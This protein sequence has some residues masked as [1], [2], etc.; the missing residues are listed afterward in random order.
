MIH[1]SS[2]ISENAV[3]GKNVEIGPFCLVGDNV[4]IGDGCVLKSHVVVK[5]HTKIGKNNVFFQFCSV[6]EDCQDKK[7]AGEDT[8]LEIGDDNVFRESCTI[9]RGTTQDNSL[10]RIG[11]RN[12][13]MVNTHVAHDCMIGSDNI[14]A[15]NAT[16]AGHVHIGDFVILGGMTAV[17]QFCHVGSHA[18]TGGGAVLLRDLPPYVMFSGIKHI[19]QGINSEGLKRRGFSSDM[20]SNIKRAYKVIYRNGNTFDEA[21][22][23]IQDMANSAEELRVMADFLKQANRGIAR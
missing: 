13:L 8:Y 6:G 21:C 2:V 20:I 7:Y 19:P 4:E 10:T 16:I 17:H 12:L 1:P 15:N 22:D 11:N 23:I 3:I 9:H 5:G 14:L 18:F